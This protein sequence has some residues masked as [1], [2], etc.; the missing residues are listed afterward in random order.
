V[1][2]LAHWDQVYAVDIESA[3]RGAQPP[4]ATYTKADDD[5]EN[6]A[7]L[8]RL[9]HLTWDEALR[10]L[11]TARQRLLEAVETIA[12][13]ADAWAETHMVARILRS[14]ALHDRHHAD[15]IKRWRTEANA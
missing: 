9:D 12:E 11:H 1:L 7:A 15:A 14:A 6:A 8:E 4:A 13:D 2:H 10:L 5:R 3:L